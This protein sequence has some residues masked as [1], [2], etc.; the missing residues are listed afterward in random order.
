MSRLLRTVGACCC[1][2]LCVSLAGLW[3]V[4]YWSGF[5]INGRFSEDRFFSIWMA[6]G[7]MYLGSAPMPQDRSQGD[8]VYY[9]NS[10]WTWSRVRRFTEKYQTSRQFLGYSAWYKENRFG[11]TCPFLL[12]VVFLIGAMGLLLKERPKFKFN[13]QEMLILTSVIALILGTVLTW[14]RHTR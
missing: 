1:L 2:L 10:Y 5:L 8:W 7:G 12:P 11:L 9:P 13:T 4:S 14:I 6:Q 3:A